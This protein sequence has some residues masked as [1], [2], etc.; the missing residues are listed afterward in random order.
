MEPWETS[1]VFLE[2]IYPHDLLYALT[3]RSPVA[4]GSLKLI[5]IPKLPASYTLITARNI[6][7]ENRLEDTNMPILA[8]SRLSYIG[9]PVALL[10]GNSRTKLEE[11][12]KQCK[13]LVDEEKPV[14]TGREA[15]EIDTASIA[16]ARE[17]L[18]GD[19][20]GEIGKPGKIVAGSYVTGIQDHWYAE[21]LGAVCWYK[22]QTDGKKKNESSIMVRTATQWPYHVKR[23]VT[24]ILGAEAPPVTVIPTSLSLHMDGKLMFSSY[25]ACHAALGTFITKKPVRLI[26]NREEDFLYSPKRFKTNIDIASVIDDK[27]NIKASDMDISVNLGAYGVN[28][29]EIIDQV[30][31]GSLGLYTNEHIKI[32]AKAHVTN[33]PPQGPFCGFGLAQGCFAIERH[34][35][36]IADIMSMDPAE[37]RKTHL[38]IHSKTH[39][40]IE[41]LINTTASMSDYYR[42][43]ASYEL[44][45]TSRKDKSIMQEKGEIFRGIGIALGYQASGLLYQGEDKG[46]YSVEVTLTKDSRLEIKSSITSSDENY[47][48][49]WAKFASE[50]LGIDPEM[51]RIISLQAPDSGPCCS[52]RN[53]TALTRLVEKC[54][55]AIKKQRFHD[56]LPI[57]VKRSVKPL[58]G[59]LYHGH[60]QSRPGKIMDISGF[61]KPGMAAAVVEVTID[62]V[63]CIPKV[64]GV[65]LGVD[66]GK[67]ISRNRARRSLN[68]SVTQALGWAFTENIEYTDGFLP[69]SSYDNFMISS[70]VDVPL[71]QINFLPDSGN[72][73]RGIGELP[74]SCIPA[75][76]LQAVSQAMDYCYRSIPLK[77]KELFEIVRVRNNQ[78]QAQV[79]K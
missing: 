35:S 72:E 29:E 68:R 46:V 65:W 47:H 34:V 20:E 13:V 73:A 12:A 40:S 49:I 9:E 3:I 10:L 5:Q 38:N 28:S 30:S 4:K 37:W 32:N 42:K 75:A 79:V 6:P 56:P 69:K 43:W 76:F 70:S 45:R 39:A 36:H 60:I 14:F 22:Q 50:I 48:K 62:L 16:A 44:L 15:E 66:G 51:V 33:I 19:P 2:D 18:I 61:A 21:P 11:M 58:S 8:D 31:L 17:V 77:R 41:P 1:S 52:S 23:S 67:I 64:R 63:D 55:Q 78:S 24:R 26:L 54:C 71:I 57:T 25:I 59:S 74:F 7:G 27:G 53:I